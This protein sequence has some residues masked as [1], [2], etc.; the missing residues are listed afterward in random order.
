MA[1][2]PWKYGSWG[3]PSN[4]LF[5]RH[6]ETFPLPYPSMSTKEIKELPISDITDN[7]CQLFLWTTQKYLPE[8]FDVLDSWGFKYCQI[9]TWC[10]TPR[11]LGQGG[12]LVPTTEFILIGRCGKMPK[13]KR[14]D[15]TWFNWKRTNIHSKKPPESYAL[16]ESISENPRIELFAR[17]RYK[18]WGAWGNEVSTD[19]QQKLNGVKVGIPPSPK[20]EGILPTFL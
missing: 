7:N 11:G 18:G 19:S 20:D 1:D 2:P 10:K 17:Q 9:I 15:T 13:I 3:K 8:A 6:N 14:I 4:T 12:L 16:I 5:K